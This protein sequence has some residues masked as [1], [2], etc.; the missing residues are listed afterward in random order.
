[1]T[2]AND[3]NCNLSASIG[4][5]GSLVIEVDSEQCRSMVIEAVSG[6][7]VSVRYNKPDSPAPCTDLG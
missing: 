3:M 4:D 5:D 7:G 2:N 1:M 6:K